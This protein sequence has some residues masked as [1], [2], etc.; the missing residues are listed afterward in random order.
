MAQVEVAVAGALNSVLF[1]GRVQLFG[2]HS[3]W[4]GRR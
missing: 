3:F 2:G 1:W 4:T